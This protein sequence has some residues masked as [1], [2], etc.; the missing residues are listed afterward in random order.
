VT[1]ILIVKFW[2]FGDILLATPILRSLKTLYPESY[3]DWL[4]ESEY[5]GILEGNS[6]LRKIV[7][8]N[9]KSWRR[10]YR[11]GNWPRYLTTSLAINRQLRKQN[12]DIVINLTPDKW[13][14][15]WFKVGKKNVGLF[16]SENSGL[17]SRFYDTV[18]TRSKGSMP[19]NTDYYL[20]AVRALGA[21]GELDRRMVC[22]PKDEDRL[23]VKEFL[24]QHLSS[25]D[26]KPMIVLHPGTSQKSKCWPAEQ[27]AH[28]INELGPSYAFVVTGSRSELK[29]AQQIK[30]LAV[31][32]SLV[33]IAADGLTSLGH[34]MALIDCAA[35]VVTGD[36]SVL[37]ISSA[38]GT[39]F[40]AIYGST[41]P[42]S[43]APLFGKRE[44]LFDDTVE[45]APCY[46]AH[47]RFRG[48][49]YLKC[50]TEVSAQQVA[51]SVKRLVSAQLRRESVMGKYPGT[52]SSED[53][54]R[55]K[56]IGIEIED[57]RR[58]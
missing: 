45:C 11:Y 31:K 44:I 9:S 27:F 12:Y 23:F 18:V 37:H 35:V 55:Q 17:L 16:P 22:E 41:R 1:R 13:W 43:N 52:G 7:H 53:F 4:V 56:Q 5:A 47:C 50:L 29:L 28:L 57:R 19:H 58:S 49:N 10:D 30:I 24:T 26:S 6:F 36:T 25:A 42:D 32:G 40:V 8:F 48:A 3:I 2:A 51:A 21:D 34:T 15:L 33:L 54:M 14:T 39:P 46:Q 38:L 20:E